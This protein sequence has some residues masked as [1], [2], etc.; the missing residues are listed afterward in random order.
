MRER[1]CAAPAAPAV[2]AVHDSFEIAIRITLAFSAAGG[3]VGQVSSC[4]SANGEMAAH[5][6]RHRRYLVQE[7]SARSA[8]RTRWI[9]HPAEDGNP[10]MKVGTGVVADDDHGVASTEQGRDWLA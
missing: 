9:P 4:S 5:D 10:L 7:G 6:R 3:S 8:L 1:K 2:A